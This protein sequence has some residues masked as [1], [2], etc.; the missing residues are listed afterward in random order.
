[1]NKL[2]HTC[3]NLVFIWQMLLKTGWFDSKIGT[4]SFGAFLI[5]VI[6]LKLLVEAYVLLEVRGLMNIL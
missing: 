1:M 3:S 4:I 6:I 5:S 2:D